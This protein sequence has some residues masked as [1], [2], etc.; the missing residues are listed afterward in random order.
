ME[1]MVD[2]VM[3]LSEIKYILAVIEQNMPNLQFYCQR[4]NYIITLY[5]QTLAESLDDQLKNEISQNFDYYKK[6]LADFKPDLQNLKPLFEEFM[7]KF[8]TLREQNPKLF[9]VEIYK[10]ICH[11]FRS[12]EL[13]DNL[14][15]QN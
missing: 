14:E 10:D 13:L 3:F 8:D 6:K 11:I 4:L 12:Y 2:K 15:Q 7:I 1:N 9:S 5:Q